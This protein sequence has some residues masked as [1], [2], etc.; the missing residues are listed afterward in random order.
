MIGLLGRLLGFAIVAVVVWFAWFVLAV[1]GPLGAGVRTDAIVVLTGGPRRVARG[2]ELMQAKSAERML[3][4]GVDPSVRPVEL[5]ATYGVPT[6]L[7]DCC[8]DLG[9]EAVDTRSNAE[10][11]AA[12]IRRNRYK[13]VRLVTAADHMRRAQLELEARLGDDAEIVPDGVPVERP[14]KP[15]LREFAKYAL[16]RAATVVGI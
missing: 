3:I 6:E 10:E 4:S 1:P 9:R 5:A 8:V 11:T 14:L 16:R 12:W 7:F 2:I 13:S 15:M